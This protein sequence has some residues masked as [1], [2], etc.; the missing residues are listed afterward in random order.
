M[1]LEKRTMA[2][3][4]Y[5]IPYATLVQ[6]PSTDDMESDEESATSEACQ[7]IKKDV[8]HQKPF[9]E[10]YRDAPS[11]HQV[12]DVRTDASTA[13]TTPAGSMCSYQHANSS[14]I[15]YYSND[16]SDTSL[17]AIDPLPKLPL[18]PY[19]KFPPLTHNYTAQDFT[20]LNPQEQQIVS[21]LQNQAAVV[22]TVK[23]SEWSSFLRRFVIEKSFR[24]STTLLP[25]KGQ[26]MRCY[27][28]T[29]E[30][31]VG[32]VFHLPEVGNSSNTAY[33]NE[34]EEQDEMERTNTW[35]WPSGYAAKTEFNVD[36]HETL[37]HGRKEALLPIKMLRE[38]NQSY[39]RDCDHWIGGRL[40]VGGLSAV[41]YN[42][43]Y[44]RIG[45]NDLFWNEN[46]AEESTN[47][48]CSYEN[49]V[50]Y[51]IALFVRTAQ[52]S[53]LVTLLRIRARMMV[54]LAGNTDYNL[55]NIP[56]LLITSENGVRVITH[57]MQ[58]ELY[59]CLA[60]SVQPFRSLVLYKTDLENTDANHMKQ[61]I[62]ELLDLNKEDIRNALT[63]KEYAVIA[64]G[65]GVTDES[66]MR[67]LMDASREHP[68]E[69]LEVVSTALLSAVRT[70]DYHTSRQIFIMYTLV[71]SHGQRDMQRV[72]PEEQVRTNI[73]TESILKSFLTSWGRKQSLHSRSDHL[74]GI[75]KQLFSQSCR[76]ESLGDA[77]EASG[78]SCIPCTMLLDASFRIDI[79]AENKTNHPTPRTTYPPPLDTS[80]LR[81]ITNSDGLLVVLG[82][83]H[84]LASLYDGGIK[85]RAM[86]AIEALDEWVE[87]GENNVAFRLLSWNSELAAQADLKNAV[88]HL[89]K[90]TYFFGKQAIENRK[91]FTSLLRNALALSEFY[92]IFF[93]RAIQDILHQM[94]CPCLRLELL[95][96]I[97]GLDERYSVSL[98]SCTVTFASFCLSISM[99]EFS[100]GENEPVRISLSNAEAISE[101]QSM[102]GE[103]WSKENLEFVLLHFHGHI[104]NS[105]NT[106]LNH[107]M[108][109]PDTLIK[110]IT[111]GNAAEAV[112]D[113][114]MDRPQASGNTTIFPISYLRIPGYVLPFS[115]S[116]IDE[117][118]APNGTDTAQ[119]VE[120]MVGDLAGRGSKML[121]TVAGKHHN[122]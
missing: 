10:N 29:K 43:V 26:K 100:V 19:D 28:S 17:S 40:V 116:G 52:Y 103:K 42:E 104:E 122:F 24:T 88:E 74:S 90:F 105:I 97:F 46:N 99:Y 50:G 34:Q 56:L 3:Q 12:V 73:C 78:C 21:L 48:S 85:Q 93:L 77:N 25:P 55:Q 65:F 5:S 11:Q 72:I 62:E 51:P 76:S 86:E 15:S 45:K 95:Q 110:A 30:Y 27:G 98:L 53:D 1:K 18:T 107:G 60:Q 35:C 115:M 32:V 4:K 33:A 54:A 112:E 58:L 37:T 39:V 7:L 2:H 14:L 31:T 106:I 79:M 57:V 59:K 119:K 102:F 66:I 70:E 81:S 114:V 82:A 89:S 121:G 87:I 23:N 36:K 8:L 44:L 83:A 13:D 75:S 94:N 20:D 41:P 47:W 49:G 108:Q 22:K 96:Y 84:I 64:G 118:C 92:D 113:T 69:L 67:A 117:L 91:Q 68:S 9:H 111:T 16:N 80:W 101:M 120:T 61:K 6:P 38:Y 109:N 71:S 63:P